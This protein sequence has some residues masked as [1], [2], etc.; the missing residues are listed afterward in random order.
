MKL[1]LPESSSSCNP[2]TPGSHYCVG[3]ITIFDPPV[4]L[5]DMLSL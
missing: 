5:A 3:G 1:S 4:P 2:V